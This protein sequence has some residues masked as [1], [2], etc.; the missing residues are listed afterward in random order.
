MSYR[1]EKTEGG[2]DIV[3][4]G[5]EKGIAQSPYGGIAKLTNVDV[6]SVPGEA[7][8][9][10][11]T[12]A[13]T[14]PPTVSALAFTV[15][16]ST[17]VFTVASTSGWYN[18][19]AITLNTVVTSTGIATGRVYWIG[20]LTATTFKLYK[21]PARNASSVVDVT[22]SNG[23]GTLTSYTFGKPLDK[24]TAHLAD[25]GS[26]YNYQFILDENGRVWWI[27]NA[28]GTPTTNLVY[29]GNDTLTGT[30]GRA[31]TI[32]KEHLIVF[33]TS[34]VDGLL[35]RSIEG[36][37]ADLDAAYDATEAGGWQ[38]AWE[39]ISSVVQNP[40]PVLVGQDDIMYYGNSDRVGSIAE[41]AGDTFELNS[42]ASWVET[43]T[44][45]D[46]PEDD[47]V[48]S[49]AELGDY[50]LVGGTRKKIYPWDRSSSTFNFP[51][52]VPEGGIKRILSV[53]SVAYIFAGT[54][55]TIYITNGVT[56][57]EFFKLPDHLTGVPKPFYTLGDAEVDNN[58][59]YLSVSAKQNDGTTAITGMDGV[60]AIDL[61]RR[62]L[63][64]VLTASHT[65]EGTMPVLFKNV[66]SSTPA[67]EG[68]YI[69]WADAN[70][71]YGV[72]VGS[73]SPY[74]G[75]EAV[76]DFDQVA[77]GTLDFEGTPHQFECKLSKP[78]VSG[79]SVQLLV[80]TT[81]NGSY[82]S[83]G[84][85]STAGRMSGKFKSPVKKIEWMQ[86]RAV[87]TS[88][89]TTPSFVPL[90]EVRARFS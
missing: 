46:I 51:L 40:R 87:L 35:L 85:L 30:T 59:L 61:T 33:R 58:Q 32:F 2:N 57:E 25:A 47:E 21:S 71:N 48:L 80:R 56:V 3:F 16:T 78:L 22:G 11:K 69:G 18:G 42:G 15:D 60:W 24:C 70:G 43:V 41:T 20:D 34:S 90:R 4:D 8:V 89:A 81:P 26:S 36:T 7:N 23:S 54:G 65:T 9:A 68:L 1:V 62:V 27:D 86:I 75:G 28:G 83:I 63:R 53:T 82:T 49:L 67:G 31:I 45:L 88:T 66:V 10:F 77:V 84:T 52:S 14:K 5:F 44:A 37:G 74:S 6:L 19:M 50:L 13:L 17:N 76:I 64:K 72:D 39:S 55:S 12:T 73:S 79:E 29:L 38:Y